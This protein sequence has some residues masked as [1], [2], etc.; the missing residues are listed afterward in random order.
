MYVISSQAFVF[1]SGPPKPRSRCVGEPRS[2]TGEGVAALRLL[3]LLRVLKL[4]NKL[5]QLQIILSG[6]AQG[7]TL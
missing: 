4:F 5:T 2:W 7:T 1:T 3:R 6:L